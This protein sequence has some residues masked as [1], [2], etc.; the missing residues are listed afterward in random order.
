MNYKIIED[1][2]FISV[3]PKTSRHWYRVDCGKVVG[4]HNC[5]LFTIYIALTWQDTGRKTLQLKP[6]QSQTF[7][8]IIEKF[9]IKKGEAL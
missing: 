3:E 8:F 4:I 9:Y 1:R 5:T 2:I 6:G 7:P